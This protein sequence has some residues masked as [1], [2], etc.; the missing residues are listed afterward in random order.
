MLL[1]NKHSLKWLPEVQANVEEVFNN[2]FGLDI[3][4]SV[5]G[6]LYFGAPKQAVV[7]HHEYV[8]KLRFLPPRRKMENPGQASS[9]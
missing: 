3:E 7:S 2:T 4:E 9:S 5:T 6:D 1:L 8:A